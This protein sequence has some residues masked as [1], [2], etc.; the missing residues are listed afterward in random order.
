MGA[1]P[2][3]FRAVCGMSRVGVVE[4][5]QRDAGALMYWRNS[6]DGDQPV[7]PCRPLRRRALARF[8]KRPSQVTRSVCAKPLE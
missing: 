1:K 2:P 5:G 7:P 3:Q 8:G 6:A 4:K